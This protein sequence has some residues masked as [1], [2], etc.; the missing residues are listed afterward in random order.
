MTSRSTAPLSLSTPETAGAF[1]QELT[2]RR[3][4]GGALRVSLW[5]KQGFASTFSGCI[6]LSIE[7]LRS[8]LAFG[9]S[10]LMIMEENEKGTK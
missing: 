6:D 1:G 3:V 2:A 8:L 10:E 5:Q 7:Q 9:A 4:E